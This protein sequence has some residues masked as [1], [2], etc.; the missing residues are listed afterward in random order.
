MSYY[1]SCSRYKSVESRRSNLLFPFLSALAV[2]GAMLLWLQPV[3]AQAAKGGAAGGGAPAASGGGATPAAPAPATPVPAAPAPENGGNNN[4]TVNP[5]AAPTP[6]AGGGRPATAPAPGAVNPRVGPRGA[7]AGSGAV[8]S[9]AQ[10]ARLAR[11]EE[12]QFGFAATPA[13][14]GNGF[15]V[16][17]LSA[18]GDLATAGLRVGDQITAINGGSLPQGSNLYAAL[19]A[20]A[21][22]GGQTSLTVLRNGVST[23]LKAQFPVRTQ[24]RLFGATAD[25]RNGQL[26]VGEVTEGTLATTAGLASGDVV[27]D[28]NGSQI[29]SADQWEG[30]LRTAMKDHTPLNM[31]IQRNGEMQT[32]Q[33]DTAARSGANGTQSAAA[34]RNAVPVSPAESAQ[35]TRSQADQFGL[36]A[37][38]AANGGGFAISQVS[39]GSDLAVAGLHAGDQVTAINGRTIAAGSDLFDSLRA[40]AAS[41]GATTITVRRGGSTT[42]LTANLASRPADAK[43]VSL[44][45]SADARDGRITVNQVTPGSLAAK[46]GLNIGDVVVDVNGK[47]VT[48]LAAWNDQLQAAMSGR[49][50]M[51]L[52]IRRNG[53]LQTLQ[54]DR[55]GM[56]RQEQSVSG[57]FSTRLDR[58]MRGLGGLQTDLK[59]LSGLT[60]GT[61]GP[62]AQQAL[63]DL[64]SL[65]DGLTL[66]PGEDRRAV[67]EQLRS[68]R[69]QIGT[70]HDD[71]ESMLKGTD[72]P[73]RRR[74]EGALARLH[75]FDERLRTLDEPDRGR[76]RAASVRF[77]RMRN[78]LGELR[79]TVRDFAIGQTGDFQGQNRQAMSHLDGLIDRLGDVAGETPEARQLRL[80]QARLQLRT[81]RDDLKGM[82]RDA[83]GEA[84]TS[85][86]ATLQRLDD[87]NTDLQPQDNDADDQTQNPRPSG[88]HP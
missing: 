20:A 7:N 81:L 62:Q 45:A 43:P 78:R 39:A 5:P 60:G 8:G 4:G 36:I 87:M 42:T 19:K 76:D 25:F 2:G 68:A 72:G 41:G 33:V 27:M 59:D 85:I 48:T 34:Q 9:A 79:G 23:T 83:T 40:A 88:T 28:V 57:Q 16:G 67:D 82:L 18:N 73:T 58:A 70:L 74:I 63:T 14:D 64:T 65:T 21:A 1:Y 56:H 17:Q 29:T 32:L 53:A 52:T 47:P 75:T 84:R 35:I 12:E 55:R 26:T 51:E 46:A 13:T 80:D 15:I 38:P 24:S 50:P 44:G 69:K 37:A 61:L 71:L 49:E 54:V 3:A 66:K 77:D 11:R 6:P 10:N 22:K 31:R 30:K 86:D